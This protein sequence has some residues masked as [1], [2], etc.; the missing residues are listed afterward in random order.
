MLNLLHFISLFKDKFQAKLR[1]QE[2]ARLKTT[3]IPELAMEY[4]REKELPTEEELRQ[5]ILRKQE[6]QLRK[7]V[8]EKFYH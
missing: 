6:L 3:S 8:N 5:Q 4:A 2:E 1:Q 7:R